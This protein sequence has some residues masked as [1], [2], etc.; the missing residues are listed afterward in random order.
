MATDIM[1]KTKEELIN[2]LHRISDICEQQKKTIESYA[3]ASKCQNCGEVYYRDYGIDLTVQLD[4]YKDMFNILADFCNISILHTIR[5][6]PITETELRE[7]IEELKNKIKHTETILS[8]YFVTEEQLN[9]GKW[10]YNIEDKEIYFKYLGN[11]D[12]TNLGYFLHFDW[13]KSKEQTNENRR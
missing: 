10:T 2:E 11:K 9:T 7:Y 12:K 5:T 8:S 3:K 1:T 6:I 13:A 4:L